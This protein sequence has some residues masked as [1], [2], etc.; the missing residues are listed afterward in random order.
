ML[1]NIADLIGHLHPLLV[2]LPIG[3]L[4]LAILLDLLAYRSAYASFRAAVPMTL[5]LGF[6]A[7]V[8]S[9]CT[10][11]L[12]SLSGDYAPQS[13]SLHQWGG[14][15]VAGLSGI[16]WLIRLLMPKADPP[17]ASRLFTGFLLGLGVLL[18]YTGH[19]GGSLTHGSDYLSLDFSE[20]TRAKKVQVAAIDTTEV[21]PPKVNPDLPLEVEQK[22]IEKL[23]ALSCNV[24][25]MLK[26]PVMLDITLPSQ[27][28]KSM[29][30]LTPPLQALAE[31][32][33]W[34]NLA[35]NGF[36]EKDLNVLK[37]LKNLEKLRLEKNPIGDGI[38]ELLVGL[39]HLEAVNLNETGVGKLAVE[40]LKNGG[41]DRVYGWG[42]GAE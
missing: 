33:V 6:V 2:H 28:G 7:A 4:L 36:T 29:A 5:F 25:V 17:K 38:V 14:F 34:L 3:F 1:L 22:Q 24:R 31:S 20:Q 40:R 26:R 16:L 18:A 37:E 10:G 35:D 9:S 15:V 41:V 11:Y 42:T 19:Q 13:L 32:V 27:S 21:Q 23:R 12:L 30:E 39:K 8:A